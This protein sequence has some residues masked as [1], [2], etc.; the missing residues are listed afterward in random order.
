VTDIRELLREATADLRIEEPD[1]VGRMR[2]A[3]ARSRRNLTAVTAAVAVLGLAIVLPLTIA[4][5][6]PSSSRPVTPPTINRQVQYWGPNDGDV[7]TGFGAVWG[8]QCCGGMSTPSWVD[9]L[10]PSTGALLKHLTIPGPTASIHAGAG[11]VWTLGAI[12]GGTSAISVINP[13]SYA[14]TTL[15]LH[16]PQQEPDHLAFSHGSAW[17]TFGVLNQVWRL[18]PTP[19]GVRKTVVRVPGDPTDIASTGNGRLWVTRALGGRSI[20]SELL[21]AGRAGHLGMSVPW[22]GDV[23]SSGGADDVLVSVGSRVISELDP[24]GRRACPNCAGSSSPISVHGQVESVVET[25]RGLFVSTFGG[26]Q[27]PGHTSF[28]STRDWDRGRPTATARI[29]G[30]GGIAADGD[31]VVVA[32]DSIGLVH[33]V[34]AG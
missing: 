10:N 18:T 23:Y 25:S 31:G 29:L 1:P 7:A 34:P 33:W 4:E 8:V 3:A 13:R 21:P 2:R 32:A 14:V 28:F 20:L 24:A 17:V 19:T 11:R 22:N 27:S 9:R 6:A 26:P 30:G 5:T 12:D 16:N 15:R